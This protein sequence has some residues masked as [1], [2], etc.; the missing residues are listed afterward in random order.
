MKFLPHSFGG[1]AIAAALLASSAVSAQTLGGGGGPAGDAGQVEKCDAPKGTLAVVEPQYAVLQSLSRYGLQSPAAVIRL[2]IQQ[3][4][5]FQIVERGAAMQNMAQERAL[6]SSGQLQGG[7]NV[8]QGQMVAADFILTPNVVF[9]DPNAGG[10]GGG[11]GGLLGQHGGASRRGRCAGRRCQ[12]QG[13]ADG[14]DDCRHAQRHPGRGGAGQC[15]ADRHQP[16][17]GGVRAL[18]RRRARGLH[19]HRR[20][21]DHRRLVPGQL[22]QHRAHHPQQPVA[23]SGQGGSGQPGQCGGQRQGGLQRGQCGR[24]V[25]GQD[26]RR[27][28]LPQPERRP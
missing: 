5:C 20:G 15:L 7:Q 24:R 21:Q 18:W 23:D 10:V 1:V 13:G 16:G 19:Q 12:V 14:D 27:E 6:A 4:N 3:S 25:R 22:E 2:I 26:C 17:R 28:G 11:I 8:G 9:S